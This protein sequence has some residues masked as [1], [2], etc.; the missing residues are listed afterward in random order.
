MSYK[1]KTQPTYPGHYQMISRLLS[2]LFIALI[3]SGSFINGAEIAGSKR[4]RVPTQIMTE[5]LSEA[6]AAKRS[7]GLLKASFAPVEP[8]PSGVEQLYDDNPSPVFEEDKAPE[9]VAA[10][11]SSSSAT[12]ELEPHLVL[13]LRIIH[14]DQQTMQ[15]IANSVRN[16]NRFDLSLIFIINNINFD[17]FV[18]VNGS[19]KTVEA[20]IISLL[21]DDIFGSESEDAEAACV[22]E[23]DSEEEAQDQVEEGAEEWAGEFMTSPG[24]EFVFDFTN[25]NILN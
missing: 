8:S 6:P 5:Y 25:D 9:A 24:E 1:T 2:T 22:Q 7:T 21:S 10:S 12:V 14:L 23:S 20:H 13:L 19:I 17:S 11:S 15:A 3:C 16:D 18:N 4:R